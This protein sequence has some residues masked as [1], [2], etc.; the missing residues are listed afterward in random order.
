MKHRLD[1][2]AQDTQ[3]EQD[4]L[5]AEALGGYLDYQEA[6]N[7]RTREAINTVDAHPHRLISEEE[8]DR[9]I[10]SLGTPDELPPP[11]LSK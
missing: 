8:M 7:Q 2:L 11:H 5:V 4:V 1:T 10:D 6:Q 9:W 3:R